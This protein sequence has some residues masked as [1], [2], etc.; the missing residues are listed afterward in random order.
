MK[1]IVDREALEEVVGLASLAVASRTPKPIL[2]GIKI[3]ASRGVLSVES[4][5]IELS[6]RVQTEKV[7][8]I[9]P[10]EAVAEC[11]KFFSICRESSDPTLTIESDKDGNV[12]IADSD[13]RYKLFGYPPGDFPSVQPE[14]DVDAFF[15][16]TG[17]QMKTLI[18]RTRFCTANENSRYAINGILIEVDGRGRVNFVATDGRRLSVATD[19][20]EARQRSGRCIVPSAS[21]SA[22]LRFI[23]DPADRVEVRFSGAF[24][25]FGV[26]PEE[27]RSMLWTSLVEGNFPPYL[28]VIPT[29]LDRKAVFDSDALVSAVSRAALLTNEESKG[30]AFDFAGGHLTITSRAP[31][32]GESEIKCPIQEWHGDNVK[33]AF[34]PK[35]ILDAIRA[36]G[37]EKVAMEVKGPNKPCKITGD[38]FTCVAMPVAL[39]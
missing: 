25:S 2:Q 23:K 29:D 39:T 15:T 7:D 24:A 6:A 33:V 11:Q 3:A 5:R 19:L 27:R 12:L 36:L 1:V 14:G 32:M 34:N 21:A 16:L 35:F 22:L 10:G 37:A 4:S 30:V 18:E 20:A 26:G 38:G 28:D 13:S 31:E 8:L 9:S 17:S